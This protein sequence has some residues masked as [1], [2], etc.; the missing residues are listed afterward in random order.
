MKIE[1]E[2][3]QY[4]PSGFYCM[5]NASNKC[6]RLNFQ[7]SRPYCELF[8]PFLDTDYSGNVL[9]C[10]RCLLAERKARLNK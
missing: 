3:E 4:C 8:Y 1:V 10:E 6:L 2:I 5:R 7:N 9:K